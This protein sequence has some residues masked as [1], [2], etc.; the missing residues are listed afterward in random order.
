VTSHASN[1]APIAGTGRRRRYARWLLAAAATFL[2]LLLVEIGLRLAGLR[3]GDMYVPDPYCGS[4]LRAGYQG[5]FTRE[6]SAYIRINSQGLRDEEHSIRRGD[7]LL[8]IAVLG[9]SFAE[10]L[11][12][13]REQTFWHVL[14]QRLNDSGLL[15]SRQAEVINFGVSGY[16]TAQEF[17]MLRHYV[18]AYDPQ[19]VVLAFYPGNDVQN[20][21]KELEPDGA[22]PFFHLRDGKLVRDDSFREHPVYVASQEYYAGWRSTVFGSSRLLQFVREA[23]RRVRSRASQ[24]GD[25]GP[26]Q[27]ARDAFRE[28][29]DERWQTAWN[30]TDQLLLEMANECRTHGAQLLV[31]V[32]SQDALVHPDQAV[33]R[34]FLAQTGTADGRYPQQRIA[35]IARRG[36][37]PVLDLTPPL[38]DYARQHQ[39]PVHGFSNASPGFGHWN[40]DGHRV[41]GERLADAVLKLLPAG[42]V[43]D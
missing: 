31:A 29:A 35:A 32:V 5:W 18:W 17:Q 2:T 6:G 41:A 7:D 26:N 20:N 34:T 43:G 39:T 11:Q 19:I 30:I 22:R 38:L 15:A 4:R 16:G 12:V 37:F 3:Y 40:A 8:R 28:P 25:G 24:G 21:S 1:P 14:E 9:D 23:Y 13:P 10:A 36:G 33:R 42:A 27:P